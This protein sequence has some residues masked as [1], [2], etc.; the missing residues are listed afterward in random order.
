MVE[1]YLIYRREPAFDK[2][3]RRGWSLLPDE[4]TKTGYFGHMSIKLTR[5]TR[6]KEGQSRI[7][8]AYN[9]GTKLTGPDARNVV[10]DVKAALDG[11]LTDFVAEYYKAGNR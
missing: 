1:A 6:G 8:I 7:G 2:K 10:N 3:N 9:N 5:I 4:G 11:V